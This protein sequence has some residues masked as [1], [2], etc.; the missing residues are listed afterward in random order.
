MDVG[1]VAD[2]K[3]YTRFR[4]LDTLPPRQPTLSST[5]R[6]VSEALLLPSLLPLPFSISRSWEWGLCMISKEFDS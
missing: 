1:H 6:S 2:N 3:S 5:I 4:A